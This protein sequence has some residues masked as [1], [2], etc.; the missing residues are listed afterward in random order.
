[1]ESGVWAFP[2]E[3]K[4]SMLASGEGR[5]SASGKA[6]GIEVIYK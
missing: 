4:K 6:M 3:T 1:M 5:K 2:E